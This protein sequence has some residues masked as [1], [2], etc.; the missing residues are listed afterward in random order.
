MI[1][2]LYDPILSM[3]TAPPVY[4]LTNITEAPN[5]NTCFEPIHLSLTRQTMCGIFTCNA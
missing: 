4:T 1:H 3:C 2:A 5:T